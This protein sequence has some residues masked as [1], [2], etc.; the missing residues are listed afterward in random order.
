VFVTV[1]VAVAAITLAKTWDDVRATVLLTSPIDL[2][3]SGGLVLAGLS[4]SVLT[5]RRCLLEMGSRVVLSAASRIYLLGQLGKYLPGSVWALFA[6]TEIGRAAG[7]PRAR[8]FAASVVAVAVNTAVGLALGVA[9]LPGASELGVGYAW[10][11]VGIAFLCAAALAPPVLTRLV[12]F[13]ITTINRPP[14]ERP[15]AW[16]GI[17]VASA[18]SGASYVAYGLS[19]WVLAVSVGAPAGQS[20]L[21]CV[22]GVPLAM[23]AGLVV[24]IAPS[25]LGVRE[26]ALVAALTPVLEPSQGLAVALLAR[27]VF[28]AA[29]FVAA[30]AVVPLRTRPAEAA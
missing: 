2:L 26:A 3:A 20:L 19:V 8:G 30:L 9:I 23:I 13:G 24:F 4:L 14:L 6:Q 28:T 10:A 18:W 21:L 25:G 12:N 27:L 1:I 5:W 15:V 17:G 11:L 16:R 29:D 22:A 7:V